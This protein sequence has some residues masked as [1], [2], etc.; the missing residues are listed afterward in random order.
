MTM[1]PPVVSI[2]RDAIVGFARDDCADKAAGLAFYTLFSLAPLLVIVMKLTSLAL[3]PA[4][5]A[6]Y[7]EEQ[8]GALIGQPG[9]DQVRT[10]LEST[11]GTTPGG[12]VASV[13]SAVVAV[14]G[15]MTVLV[16]LQRSLNHVWR[17]EQ[18]P[19]LNLGPFLFKRL[20]SLAMMAIIAFLLVVSLVASAAVGAASGWF[21]AQLPPILGSPTSAAIDAGVSLVVFAA[22]FS[23]MFKFL[24][25]VSVGW[26]QV[27]IGGVVTSLLF[28]AGKSLIG[29]YLGSSAI[30]SFYGAAGSL[31]VVLVWVYYNAI[32][33]LFGAELTRACAARTGERVEPEAF[34]VPKG[35]T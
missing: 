6:L 2:L 13:V 9:A 28:V 22:V 10:I 35:A 26:K 1:G 23:C 24:P 15:A 21:A 25:D 12:T 17:V 4:D 20:I 19:G 31:A 11:S 34:A 3:D 14:L 32:L 5:M 33:V 29:R 16:Q 30:A 27:W 8:A 7:V 18:A